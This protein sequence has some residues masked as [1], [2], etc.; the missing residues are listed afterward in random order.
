MLQ[1]TCQHHSEL[2]RS[3][4]MPNHRASL[5]ANSGSACAERWHDDRVAKKARIVCTRAGS[6]NGSISV[7]GG[8]PMSWPKIAE[9]VTE[10]IGNTPMVYLNRVVPHGASIV[11]KMETQEPCK[12]VKDRIGLNM[13]LDAEKRGLITPGKLDCYSY[14]SILSLSDFVL[15]VYSCVSGSE[16]SIFWQ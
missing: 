2:A 8:R 12:S 15:F 5:T 1:H 3:S 11:A 7:N 10:V 13:I 6:E 14:Y 4:G 16:S 9:N